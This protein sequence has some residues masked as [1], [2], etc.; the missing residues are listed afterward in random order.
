MP[1]SNESDQ[2]YQTKVHETLQ[3]LG[4][5]LKILRVNE[6]HP[7]Y[8]YTAAIEEV[9]VDGN[10]TAN[11]P[12]SSRHNRF[13]LTW[14]PEDSFT[15][16]FSRELLNRGYLP[17]QPGHDP[18]D[19]STAFL[20]INGSGD[21]SPTDLECHEAVMERLPVIL[22]H[23]DNFGATVEG[24]ILDY[25]SNERAKR[26]LESILEVSRVLNRADRFEGPIA[27]WHK[28]VTGDGSLLQRV[29]I[30]QHFDQ[31]AELERRYPNYVQ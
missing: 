30:R 24:E 11:F 5:P 19:T 25:S 7:G 21:E 4:Y 18:F 13:Y 29:Q 8:K 9:D 31:M 23:I 28:Y 14:V 3:G 10:V 16:E 20:R 17:I 1:T 2:E 27:E 6:D 22:K 15:G 26:N 12:V